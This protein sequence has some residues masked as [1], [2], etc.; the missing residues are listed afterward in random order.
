MPMRSSRLRIFALKRAGAPLWKGCLLCLCCLALLSCQKQSSSRVEFPKPLKDYPEQVEVSK[1]LEPEKKEETPKPK[2]ETTPSAPAQY[3]PPQPDP[4]RTSFK[5]ETLALNIESLPLPAFINEVYGNILK[6]TFEIAPGLREAKDLV[7]LRTGDKI[8]PAELDALVR[9][10]LSNYGVAVETQ[11]SL[12]RFVPV[13]EGGKSTE[14]PLMVSGRALPDVPTSHRPIFQYVPLRVAPNAK[15]AEWLTQAYKGYELQVIK[16]TVHNAVLLIGNRVIVSQALEAL[17]VLD[18]PS[19]RGRHSMRVEPV[20]LDADDMAKAL[21]DVMQAE[22]YSASSKM[23]SPENT[24]VVLPLKKV[25]AVMVFAPEPSVLAH[26]KRWVTTIDK[27]GQGVANEDE[28]GIFYY[29]VQ[30][31]RAEEIGQVVGGLAAR[32]ARTSGQAGAGSGVSGSGAPT[33]GVTQSPAYRSSSSDPSSAKPTSMSTSSGL[34]S[35]SSSSSGLG[36]NT[37]SNL[38][39]SGSSDSNAYATQ[40]DQLVVDKA[41]NALVYMGKKGHWEKLLK[42]IHEMDK[43]TRMVL[44]EVT[45][46]EIKL[47]DSQTLGVEWLLQT[48]RGSDPSNLRGTISTMG[49]LGVGS[50]GMSVIL[51]S[52]GQTRAIL[53]AFASKSRVSVLSTPRIMVRSGG[54]ASI[55]V[56]KEV[57]TVTGQ[58]ANTTYNGQVYQQVQYRKTGILLSVKPVIHSGRRVDLEISQEVSSVASETS[59]GG[60]IPSPTIANRKIDTSIGL[61]DGGSILLGGLIGKD[62]NNSYSGVPILSDIPIV[63]RAFRVQSDSDERTELVMLIVPYI[64]DNDKDASSITDAFKDRLEGITEQKAPTQIIR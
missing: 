12:L 20:Y 16:D 50:T 38:D 43:Q 56:G 34:S 61:K 48:A 23:E 39:N 14:P 42:V 1:P 10:V 35:G 51:D 62:K 59:G 57:P 27:P 47:G 36:A 64:I 18:Q 2:F 58:T 22:G 31:T 49:G 28:E 13:K 60:A 21:V 41:R 26:I 24:V 25:G 44:I 11:G 37:S 54:K 63:G 53:N 9:Q 15:V 46:A 7:T 5:G 8:K 55:E 33:R 40:S 4:Q 29:S 30:N 6:A 19:M 17:S 32:L 52:A 3:N 45:V